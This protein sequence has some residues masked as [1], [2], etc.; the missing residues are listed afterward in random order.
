MYLYKVFT[1]FLFKIQF[2]LELYSENNHWTTEFFSFCIFKN[3]FDINSTEISNL[4]HK[5]ALN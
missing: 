3:H 2:K 5:F 1:T 4:Q